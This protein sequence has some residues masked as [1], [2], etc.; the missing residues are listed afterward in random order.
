MDTGGHTKY[1]LWKL[2]T[3]QGENPFTGNQDDQDPEDSM[4]MDVSEV[5][6]A[7]ET[8][9]S[10]TEAAAAPC[11]LATEG[12]TTQ[13]LAEGEAEAGAPAEEEKME[14]ELGMQGEEELGNPEEEEGFEVGEEEEEGYVV[15]DEIGEEGLQGD[16]KEGE[17]EAAEV[18]KEAENH[19]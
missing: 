15:H 7:N 19:E 18:E 11:E 12:E 17:A 10:Q 2:C 6:L 8:T 3:S 16:V 5:E 14:E 13:E 4:V 9:D 1:S